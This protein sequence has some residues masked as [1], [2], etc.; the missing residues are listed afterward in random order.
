[1]FGN[2]VP[3]EI[4]GLKRDKVKRKKKKLHKDELYDLYSSPNISRV[5]KSKRMRWAMQ[6]AHM[7]DRKVVYRIL[8]GIPKGKSPLERPRRI[9]E[10]NIKM[11]LQ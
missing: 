4:F 2:R 7:G 8:V 5:I 9:W 6:I 3:K 10:C 11:A 1:V